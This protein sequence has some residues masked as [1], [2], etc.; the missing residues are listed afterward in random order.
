MQHKIKSRVHIARST[1]LWFR[2]I[3][4]VVMLANVVGM[5]S[6]LRQSKYNIDRTSV[7]TRNKVERP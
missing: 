7:E 4:Q 2:A 5:L 3:V 6:E 1:C